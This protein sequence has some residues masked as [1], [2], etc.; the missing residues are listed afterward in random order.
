MHLAYLHLV[1]GAVGVSANAGPTFKMS[2]LR[3]QYRGLYMANSGYDKARA[4]DALQNGHADL[5]SFGTL[6]LANPDLPARFGQNAPLNTPDQAT[7]YGGNEKG[8]TD[9]PTLRENTENK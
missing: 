8:Y 5:I 9:Y 4:N 2:K 1:E 7:F 6:F 3:E